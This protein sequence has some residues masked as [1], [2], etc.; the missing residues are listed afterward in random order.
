MSH[1]FYFA[2]KTNLGFVVFHLLSSSPDLVAG[3]WQTVDLL[4]P[5]APLTA[6]ALLAAVGGVV[7]PVGVAKGSAYRWTETPESHPRL[8]GRLWTCGLSEADERDS[9]DRDDQERR[10]QPK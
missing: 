10:D 5:S 6:T 2:I 4:S 1:A 7:K 3:E 8:S 9:S